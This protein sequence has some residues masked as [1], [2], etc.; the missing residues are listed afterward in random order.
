M[1]CGTIQP[2]K[3]ELYFKR[4]QLTENMRIKLLNKKMTL[5]D[6]DKIK[7]SCLNSEMIIIL[8]HKSI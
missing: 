7:E 3:E 2:H 6:W 1:N 8:N 4:Q 5:I